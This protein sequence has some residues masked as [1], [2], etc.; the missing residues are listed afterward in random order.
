MGAVHSAPNMPVAVGQCS[1]EESG[2]RANQTGNSKILFIL[3]PK[4]QP[5][6]PPPPQCAEKGAE[7]SSGKPK[8]QRMSAA[9]ENIMELDEMFGFTMVKLKQRA[10]TL[11]LKAAK[12][13]AHNG[14]VKQRPALSN[15]VDFIMKTKYNAMLK[16]SCRELLVNEAMVGRR[17]KEE[18]WK[19]D[20]KTV[21]TNQGLISGIEKL[22]K[23]VSET[24]REN[25]KIEERINILQQAFCDK[26]EE[27]QMLEIKIEQ[28]CM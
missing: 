14:Y 22:E 17:Y 1:A 16:S 5:P 12:Y 9:S 10:N 15:S 28:M 7:E 13:G 11:N 27:K 3:P 18:E 26:T 24:M 23:L 6:P 8:Y 2:G 21:K 25:E 20:P 4:L 19:R